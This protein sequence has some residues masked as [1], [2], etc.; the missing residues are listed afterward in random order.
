M[1]AHST[2]ADAITTIALSVPQAYGYVIIVAAILAL[3]ILFIGFLYPGAARRKVFSKEFIKNNFS[4]LHQK[5]VGGEIDNL[6]GYPDM[7]SGFYSQKL[8]YKQ[9]YDF[10]IAQRV[11]YNFLEMAPSTFVSLLLGGLYFPIAS[12][13]FGLGLAVFRLVYCIGYTGKGPK[14]KSIGAAGNDFCLLALIILTVITGWRI[15]SGAGP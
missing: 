14:G 13:G 5:E 2:L 1:P 7:G 6:L 11:H 12:A 9:W 3:E 15:A 8:S 4:E 10:N